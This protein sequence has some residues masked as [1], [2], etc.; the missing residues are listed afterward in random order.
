MRA[1][2]L[3]HRVAVEERVDVQ[4]DT[5]GVVSQWRTRAVVWASVEPLSGREQLTA[6]QP[7]AINSTRIRLRWVP[8]I[9]DLDPKW[10]LRFGSTLYNLISVMNVEER[11]REFE[12][13]C[14]SGSNEG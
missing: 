11:N 2:K 7:L 14:S 13:L 5:G 1:G 8:R 10:R 9:A 3:R 6:A 12:C 4:D